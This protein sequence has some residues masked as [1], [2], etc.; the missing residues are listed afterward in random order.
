[1]CPFSLAASPDE[2]LAP[3]PRQ[4]QRKGSWVEAL[5][6]LPRLGRRMEG[7]LIGSWAFLAR[8][9]SLSSVRSVDQDVTTDTTVLI[10]SV[11]DLADTT[12]DWFLCY[13]PRPIDPG[14]LT[15]YDPLIGALVPLCGGKVDGSLINGA[16]VQRR[17]CLC[18]H[19]VVKPS[20]PSI[21]LIPTSLTPP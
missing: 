16:R 3:R 8:S 15:L 11:P 20:D 13:N 18:S 1:M 21:L 12:H 2:A 9:L 6:R 7:G 5:V 4:G 10:R 19:K 17:L 14:A